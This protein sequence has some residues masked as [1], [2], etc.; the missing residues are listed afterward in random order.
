MNSFC[1]FWYLYSISLNTLMFTYREKFR[2]YINTLLAFNE[3]C[4]DRYVIHLDD[5]EDHGNAVLKVC[6]P[7]NFIQ[8]LLSCTLYL[9]M[10]FQPW[11]LTSYV[12]EP[13]NPQWWLLLGALQEWIMAGQTIAVFCLL[14]WMSVAHGN[15]VEFWLMEAHQNNDTGYTTGHLRQ[16]HSVIEMYRSLQVLTGL[17]N[18]CI[19][20]TAF[21]IMKV[22][23]WT[24]LIS[25]G[26]VLIRSMNNKFIEEFPAILTYPF[27]VVI[28]VCCS[29]G[30]LQISAEMFDMATSFL[31]SWSQTKH[32]NLRRIMTSCA[33]LRINVGRFYFVTVNTT[34]TYFQKT[35]DYIIDCIITFP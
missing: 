34:V 15:S 19:A 8:L 26:Y 21:P 27:G 6:I 30:M 5:L 10:P 31:N 24:A 11:Y 33:T 7:A 14:A 9:F 1:V 13:G 16:A 20:P 23:N 29:Y 12:Y 32:K 25:C 17:L 3:E 35:F 22:V 4:V 18:E 28:C 2:N